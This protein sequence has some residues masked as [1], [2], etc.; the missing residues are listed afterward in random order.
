MAQEDYLS[1]SAFGQVYGS[2]LGKRNKE[3]KKERNKALLATVLF[4]TLGALQL[5]QK[6]KIVDGSND[7][8]DKYTD[9]FQN[10]QVLY[11]LQNENR[12]KYQS[13]LEDNDGYLQKEAIRLFNEHPNSQAEGI[14]YSDI[15]GLNPESKKHAMAEYTRLREEAEKTILKLGN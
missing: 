7:V 3:N 4:E 14:Q 13:Y 6:Q 5:N 12:A 9:I 2:L 15:R 1:C 11:E 8:K 10:N